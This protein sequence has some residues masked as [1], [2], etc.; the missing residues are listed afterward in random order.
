M[1]LFGNEKYN[2]FDNLDLQF[3]RKFLIPCSSLLI[4]QQGHLSFPLSVT[5]SRSFRTKV[6]DNMLSERDCNTERVEI[7][8]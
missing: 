6:K 8:E 7:P 3:Y 1:K 5:L 4:L 2:V